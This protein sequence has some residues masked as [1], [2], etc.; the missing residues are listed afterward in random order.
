AATAPGAE[1]GGPP[2]LVTSFH[3]AGRVFYA[4]VDETWRWRYRTGDAHFK[5]FWS[6]VFRWATA[7]RLPEGDGFVRIGTDDVR[8]EE[9]ATVAVRA[10]LRDASGS[11]LAE[12]WVE[13]RVAGGVAEAPATPGGRPAERRVRLEVVPGAEGLYRGEIEDLP[14][15]DYKVTVDLPAVP[16]YTAVPAERRA[17][18]GFIVE[19]PPERE[20]L[21][22]AA[23]ASLLGE[24]A[25]ISGGEHLRL[26]EAQRLEEL[27]PRKTYRTETAT[28][29]QAWSF[30]WWIA[31]AFAA[32]LAAEWVLRKRWELV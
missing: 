27:L 30:A 10:S 19:R 23:D 22:L 6:Q 14:A 3:G 25:R 28:R 7:D 4:A 17:S 8:Y 9:P 15:G 13:A 2:A 20:L 29:T 11:P 1:P 26:A 12:E 21:D 32:L 24:V 18:V 16:E 31:G 5:R